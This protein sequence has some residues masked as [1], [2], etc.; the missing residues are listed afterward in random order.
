MK[1]Q[2]GVMMARHAGLG[3]IDWI[4]LR[5]ARKE[6]VVT[7]PTVYVDHDGLAGDHAAGAKRAVTLI[8]HE[9]MQVIASLLGLDAVAPARLRRNL[10]V[11]GLNLYALRKARLQIGTAILR[12]E[13]PCPPCS[14]MEAE[15]GPGGYNAI[16]GHGGWY[17]SVETPGTIKLGDPVS[18][19]P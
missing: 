16:R 7:V 1:G 8:Q 17:A 18:P 12:V 11:S 3:R 5:P 14:R 19:D 10:V 13:G 4:G 9:H 2:L 6:P 15:F